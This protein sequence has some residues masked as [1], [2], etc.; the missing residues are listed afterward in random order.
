MKTLCLLVL[1]AVLAANPG[2]FS[3]S[4]VRLLELES[5]ESLSETLVEHYEQMS[6]HP[7]DINTSSRAELLSTGFFTP[8][9]VASIL[10][11]I[12][13]NGPILSFFELSGIIGIGEQM[14]DDLRWFLRCDPP[15][16]QSLKSNRAYRPEVKFTGSI[17]ES[18]R[19][20][21]V[22]TLAKC[23]LAYGE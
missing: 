12:S 23:E 22:G 3:A 7:L 10:D 18:V 4:L 6:A 14:A 11:Y 13:D 1:S 21:G 9:Q 19:P 20:S 5:V 2:D 17:R 8:F 15:R 16:R